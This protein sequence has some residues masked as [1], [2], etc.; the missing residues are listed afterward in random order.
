MRHP[1]GDGPDKEALV[2]NR[3][4][5]DIVGPGVER[6]TSEKI[7]LDIR[8]IISCD[9]QAVTSQIVANRHQRFISAKITDDGN[10]QIP[11][12]EFP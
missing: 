7:L 5:F 1:S 4:S 8:R 11:A 2:I 12:I 10:Q 3:E 9:G 6:I